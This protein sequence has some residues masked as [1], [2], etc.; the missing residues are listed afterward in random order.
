MREKWNYGLT[1][2]LGLSGLQRAGNNSFSLSFS[3]FGLTTAS[4]FEV[5]KTNKQKKIRRS[6]MIYRQLFC[7]QM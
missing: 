6:K 1:L 7:N 5:N 2:M 3:D 4:D